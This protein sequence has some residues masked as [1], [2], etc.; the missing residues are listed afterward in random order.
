MTAAHE[1]LASRRSRLIG[2]LSASLA[3]AAVSWWLLA[4]YFR[5]SIPG[6]IAF[7]TSD[8]PCRP[9]QIAGMDPHCWMDYSQFIG[10]DGLTIGPEDNQFISN[11]P[12]ISRIVFRMFEVL[13][14]WTGV[15]PALIIFLALSLVGLAIPAWWAS[16]GQAWPDRLTVIALLGIGTLPTL[17]TL[18]RGNN[19]GLLMPALLAFAVAVLTQRYR[20]A[21]VMIVILAQF[22]PQFLVLLLALMA[23]RQWRS[24]IESFLASMVVMAVSFV[25]FGTQALSQ[26]RLFV[27]YL[28]KFNG[29][30]PLSDGYPTNISFAR[31]I[32]V[33][34]STVVGLLPDGMEA[35]IQDA[36]LDFRGPSLSGF[37]FAGLV[38]LAMLLL[39]SRLQPLLI[40][41]FSLMI[42]VCLPSITNGYYAAMATV[43]GAAFLGLA[44]ASTGRKAFDGFMLAGIV[45]SLSLV[46]IPYGSQG[47]RG[48]SELVFHNLT[49]LL[50]TWVWMAFMVIAVIAAWRT[51]RADPGSNTSGALGSGTTSP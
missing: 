34:V 25:A 17:A 43:V 42:A 20:T 32:H 12:P 10:L 8:G 27:E 28:V 36:W 48:T 5:A 3:A 50:A 35:P 14:L 46:V 38:A 9:I 51:A 30:Q 15:G 41:S 11:Y 40:V 1:L 7:Y 26:M 23:L 24:A 29:Y 22:K 37:A 19:L 39:G 33:L 6:S 31:A 47:A 44:T 18:D 16:R 4:G 13:G 49:P 2:L 21:A 45:L